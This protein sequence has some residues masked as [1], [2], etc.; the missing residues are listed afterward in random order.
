MYYFRSDLKKKKPVNIDVPH[1]KRMMCLNESSLNPFS[2]LRNEFINS[3]ENVP[4]NRYFNEIT[5]SFRKKLSEYSK[6]PENCLVYGNGAD[7][8][9]YYLFNAVRENN[10]SFAVS[11]SPSYFDY[12]S[13]SA[14]VGLGIKFLHL[15]ENYDFNTDKFLELGNSS[16]CKLFILC[17]PNNPT[18]NLLNK[19]KISNI[20]EK[21]DRLVLI[22]ETYFEFSGVTFKDLIFKHRNLVI[23]RSFSKAF[24]AAGLRFGYLIS[25]PENIRELE[26][27]M[28]IFHLNLMTQAF[29]TKILENKEIFM[30]HNKKVIEYRRNVYRELSKFPQILVKNSDTNFLVFTAGEKTSDLFNYLAENEIALRSVGAHPLLKDHLRVTI[31]SEE[32]NK[33]FLKKVKEFFNPDY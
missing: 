13:Y 20:I 21:T 30:E 12:K 31:S 9:L 23:I 32:D 16:D 33:Y 25:N 18:G 7:E 19:D 5:K 10:Y 24:S 14:A 11:L 1:K 2:V 17:N 4:L 22:D 28:T 29:V 26:K 3:L 8:M 15:D 6:V 27:V